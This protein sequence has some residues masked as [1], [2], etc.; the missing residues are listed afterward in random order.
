[1]ALGASRESVLSLVLRQGLTLALAGTAGG[2]AGALMLTR[3][4]STLLYDTSPTD[5]PTF[6]VTSLLFLL[7]AGLACLAPARQITAIDPLSALRRE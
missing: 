3:L 4:V 2:I 7:V 1:M 6:V 5:A